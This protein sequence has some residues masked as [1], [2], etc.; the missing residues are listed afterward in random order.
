MNILKLCFYFCLLYF[1]TITLYDFDLSCLKLLLKITLH[2]FLQEKLCLLFSTIL[3]QND[4]LFSILM[5]SLCPSF[6]ALFVYI[7]YV[8][9]ITNVLHGANLALYNQYLQHSKTRRNS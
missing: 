7:S 6:L 8:V 5:Q 2:V 9:N 4:H 1:M 3:K